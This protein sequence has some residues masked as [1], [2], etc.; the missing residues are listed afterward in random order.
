MGPAMPAAEQPE[1]PTLS[2]WAEAGKVLCI[3]LDSMG[4]VLM[5]GPAV[6]AVKE[7]S[8]GRRVSF[9][10]S[11]RGAEA[12]RLIPWIGEVIVY[13]AP[14]MKATLPRPESAG[15]L[16]AIEAIRSA[17][18]EG[19]VI[20]TVYSQSSLPAALFCYLADIPLRLAYCRENP[21]QLLTDHVPEDEPDGAI[22]DLCPPAIGPA[23]TAEPLR[24]RH[25][26][27][28]QL[29]LVAR[30]GCT[31]GDDRLSMRIPA[32]AVESVKRSLLE[33]GVNG[34]AFV[35]LHPGAGARSRRYPADGFAEVGRYLAGE[36]GLPV[37]FTGDETEGPL[38]EAVRQ[39]MGARSHTLAGRLRLDE[40]AALL[41]MAA[42][43][44]S[45]NTGPA[46]IAAAV[47]TP[48]VSLYALTNPQHVPWKVPSR[49]LFHDVP[50][51]YCYKSVCPR[52]TNDCLRLVSPE[53][54]IS[55]ALELLGPCLRSA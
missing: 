48:V 42:L 53:D 40:L 16:A 43:L 47:G 9:L 19:A 44:V 12:A 45:N 10:T 30:I 49:V 38:I 46:H 1:R 24:I 5:T 36:A 4:D 7:S 35:V 55:A 31:T 52:G 22:T 29:D 34:G 51:K 50:C 8:P 28:R 6:R 54:V 33:L 27:R 37:I 41:S 3:R 15:D 17:A 21:Y 25:E 23:G 2:S 32:D 18:F 14:W 13:D 26:V 11:S 20:F 39:R